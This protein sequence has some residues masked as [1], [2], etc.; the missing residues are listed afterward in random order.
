MST[1]F[2]RD[3]RG[4]LVAMYPIYVEGP[5]GKSDVYVAHIDTGFSGQL[6]LPKSIRQ[7]LELEYQRDINAKFANLEVKEVATYHA[8]VYWDNDWRE[9]TV[10]ETGD[11]PLIGMELLRDSSVCFDAVERGPIEIQSLKKPA[12]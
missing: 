9:V 7:E 5:T 12:N 10:L 2:V 8:T 1:G 6:I 3:I 11:R 4:Q